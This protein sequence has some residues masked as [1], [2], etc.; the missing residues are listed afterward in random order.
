[1]IDLGWPWWVSLIIAL[2]V[3]AVCA[4]ALTKTRRG[5]ARGVLGLILV[6]GV[7]LGVLSP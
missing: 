5:I 2:S 7:A 3:A 6:Q 4:A 1:M